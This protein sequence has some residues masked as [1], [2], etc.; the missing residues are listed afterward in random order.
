MRAWGMDDEG[1]QSDPNYPTGTVRISF[2]DA[3][4]RFEILPHQA[5]DYIDAKQALAV[6][7]TQQLSLLYAGTLAARTEVDVAV[8]I[9]LYSHTSRTNSHCPITYGSRA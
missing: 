4:H 1:M 9:A 2:S 3:G 8:H 7:H 6:L 5:Y